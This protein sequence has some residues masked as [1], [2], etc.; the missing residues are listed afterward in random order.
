MVRRTMVDGAAP[1]VDEA[2]DRDE[3]DERPPV[4]SGPES[5]PVADAVDVGETSAT[6]DPRPAP[7]LGR[8][9]WLWKITFIVFLLAALAAIPYLV[10]TGKAAV[11]D[12][13]SGRVIGV[14]DDPS[15]PGYE[16]LVEPT[17]TLLLAQ[18][19]GDELVGVTFLS[20]SSATTGSA[21][22][23]PPDLAVAMPEGPVTLSDVWEAGGE[24]GLVGAVEELLG[25]GIAEYTDDGTLLTSGDVP[26]VRLDTPQWEQLVAPVA[27]I[28]VENPVAIEVPGP[29]GAPE[30]RFPAGELELSAQMV[31]PYLAARNPG[32]SDLNRMERHR[33][34]WEAWIDS[35][36]AAGADGGIAG[37]QDSGLGRY[38]R[39]FADGEAGLVPVQAS[40]FTVPG[41]D[42]DLYLADAEVLA[43]QIAAMVPFPTS[44]SPGARP[45]V[46]VLDGTGTPDASLL[47]AEMLARD[48]GAEIR[49]IG[50]GPNFDYTETHIIYYDP[51]GQPAAEAVR[52]ALGAGRIELLPN[53]DEVATVTVILGDDAIEGLDL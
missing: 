30:V 1:P 16:V 17:P 42:G 22:F 31:G 49:M 11:E 8:G 40:T 52:E 4:L 46:E 47:A 3:A 5:V 27:P 20:T 44:P 38:L 7:A 39:T 35:V 26:V 53:P 50:N 28:T 12:S 25:V 21:L 10:V 2:P 51:A 14:V 37:E 6:S 19:E 15:A 13:T 45:A 48:A 18:T 43:G 32:E 23:L 29:D 33:V 9:S 34:F 41:A 24:V 36:R